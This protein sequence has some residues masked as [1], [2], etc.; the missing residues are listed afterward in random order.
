MRNRTDRRGSG[1]SAP[2]TAA[3][4]L[5][6]LGLAAA[7]AAEGFPSLNAT[8]LDHIPLGGFPSNPSSGS[9]CW[10][11]VSPSG[12]EYALMG[13]REAVAV[14]EIT[15]PAGPVLVAEISH[16]NSNWCDIKTFG[17]YCYAV[18]E[19][20]GG[21]DVIDLSQVDDGI[22]TLV[23]R[24]TDG[25]LS[26]CHN[27][28]V[29]EDSRYL[30]LCAPGMLVNEGRL[31]AMD[32]SDPADPTIAGMVPIAGGGV[33]HDAQIVS[34]TT[35]PF[36]GKEI[37]FCASGSDH[38]EIY[39]VT[40]KS[41]MIRIAVGTYPNMS[42]THQCWLSDDRRYLYVNDETD[43]INE[44]VI[45]DV[46]D[47]ANPLF[48]TTY[49]SGVAATDHNV[50][51]HDGF[52]YEAEYRAGLRIFDASDPVNP[53]QVGWIDTFPGD[54]SAG[55]GGV[56][57][58]YPFFPSG[59]VILG[60]K[61]RGLFVVWPDT[62][63]VLF[64]FPGGTPDRVDPGGGVFTVD[65]TTVAGH[66]LD[67]TSAVLVYDAGSGPVESPM[68][69]VGGDTF[70]ASF[71]PLPCGSFVQFHVR[72][73]TTEAIAIRSPVNA[74]CETFVAIVA[75]ES[76]TILD[77]E[78]EIA[79]GWTAGVLG[80]TAVAGI[81]TRVDPVGN[82]IQPENDHTAE[83]GT[84]CFVTGQASVGG[85][86]GED[87]VDGGTTTLLSPLLDLSGAEQVSIGYW[88]WYH[89]SFFQFDADEGNSPSED[90]FVVSISDNDGASWTTVETVGPAGPETAGGWVLHAFDVG[91]LV[92]LTSQVRMRFVAS[93]VGALSIVE[94]AIDDFTVVTVA[95]GDPC[96][97]D[98]NGDGVINVLDLIDLLLCFGL[99][100]DPPCDAG[101]DVNGDGTVN[102]LDLIDLLLVFGT[103]CP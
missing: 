63:P 49:T 14:V 60:D 51:Y 78:F 22:V 57:G 99:P 73:A 75:D 37:A 33:V 47:V 95:C 15:D 52:I 82:N 12:R 24:V 35:G 59:K 88:R 2:A 31:V 77:D 100:A 79:T 98:V 23:Q 39:D 81:W 34:Y 46:G 94:A 43:N 42:Y 25:G 65:I 26:T 85:S 66:V 36:A 9:D 61:N 69:S 3:A 40:D 19:T 68:T 97:T 103:A 89:N 8:L 32:L 1:L 54:D 91:A 87:D 50:F 30:Y 16:S 7:A 64:D 38:L 72:A 18:N 62:P 13:L 92:S 58:V 28:A 90:V 86:T 6:A 48:V 5:L 55:S 56:W 83:P 20:G 102:V 74:P 80:D 71:D 76:T 84:D 53:V 21:L 67:P 44:T 11:Y 29:N 27:I 17:T 41:A 4:G 96:P 45:F 101:Q 10:G 93:D 70:E